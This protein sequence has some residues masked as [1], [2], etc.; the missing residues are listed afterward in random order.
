MESLSGLAAFVHAAE[1]RSYVAAG[2]ILGVSS[3]AVAKSARGSRPGSASGCS[4][5]RRAAS[6]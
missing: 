6:G 2:R 5:G 3:S 1:Q 4:T